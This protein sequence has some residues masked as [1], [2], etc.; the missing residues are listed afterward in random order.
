MLKDRVKNGVDVRIVHDDIGSRK[1]LSSKTRALLKEAGVK[2]CVFNRLIPIF[3]LALNIRNHR[4]IMVIDG[5]IAY[6]GGCNLADE[7]VNEKRMYGYWKDAGAKLTGKAVDGFTLMFLRQWEFLSKQPQEYEKFLKHYE[8]ND[9]KSAVV[10]YADGL[11][12][13]KHVAKGVYENM[14]A[15]AKDYI[16][17]MTPYFIID[18]TIMELLINKAL[19]GVDITLVIPEIPDKKYAYGLTRNNAEKLIDYGIKVYAMRNSFVHS[20]VVL[21]EYAVVVGSINMDFRSFYQQ[22]ECAVY[23]NDKPFMASVQNDFEKTLAV[24]KQIS[25]RTKL[26]RNWLYRVYA[27]FMQLFAPFM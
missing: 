8:P 5:K 12:F 2:I 21:N 19:S 10:C 14:I 6:T 11:D 27:G 1:M 24:S 3:S 23:T 20:K 22:F 4:K 25:D 9:S 17:I 18:D 7:Y 15:N 13:E 16:K 26:R